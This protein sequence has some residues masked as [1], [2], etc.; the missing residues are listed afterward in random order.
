MSRLRLVIAG[1][2]ALGLAATGCARFNAGSSRPST[3]PSP[4]PSPDPN[5]L[6]LRVETAGG[7]VAP[8]YA[9]GQVPE[10]SL[11]ADGQVVTVGPQITIYPGPALPSLLVRSLGPEG[12][13]AVV[14]AARTAG[15]DGPDHAY[16]TQEIADAPTTTF[17]LVDGGRRHVISAYALDM[18][19]R[20]LPGA[21]PAEARA[22]RALAD[23]RSKLFDL[24]RWLPAGSVGTE[25]RYV[26][27]GVRVFVAPGPARDVG[28]HEP[29]LDWPLATPL[30]TFGSLVAGRRDLRC[31]TVGG[32]D[33]AALRP[34]FTQANQLTPWRSRGADFTLVLR[35]LL[36]DESG[37]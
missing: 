25:S 16:D 3:V 14:E 12:V 34:L 32:A 2:L 10:F 27:E 8:E 1:T 24:S 13:R 20:P 26:P 29:P 7:F 17:T 23:L 11:L 31:G 6:L 36:P 5:A 37:C 21:D 15:L 28:L 18:G 19:G 30:S 22:R 4:S 33:L 9:L 35:P